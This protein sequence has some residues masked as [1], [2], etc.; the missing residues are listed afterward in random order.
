MKSIVILID[1][2]G[3][4]PKWFPVFL[5]SCAS[6]STVDWIIRTDCKIPENPP[7]N[8]KFFLSSYTDY[9]AAVSQRL[10]INFKPARSYKICDLKAMYGD[11][12]VDDIASYDYYGFG[13]LDVIYGDIRKFYTDEVLSFD[14]ISTH[15]GMISGH[16]ALFKNTERMRKAYTKILNWKEYLENPNPTRFDEDIYSNLFFRW[17]RVRGYDAI[18]SR[19]VYCKE[20]YSTVFHTMPWHDGMADHPDIWFWKNGIVTNNRNVGREYLYLHLMNFQSMRWVNSACRENHIP[21]K[22]NPDML[23]TRAGEESYGV[24]IDWS[25]IQRL[26]Y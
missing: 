22:D 17:H 25:G 14:V 21:W 13:D 20:Q 12:Y 7:K 4:W 16:L 8:V 5:T 19:D 2:F 1:Y 6:N 15:V 9:V 11:M 23:F 10:G 3:N 18:Y 26:T 24:R